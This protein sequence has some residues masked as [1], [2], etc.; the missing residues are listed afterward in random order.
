M[1]GGSVGLHT[2]KKSC[3]PAAQELA[4]VLQRVDDQMCLGKKK[5]SVRLLGMIGVLAGRESGKRGF[6]MTWFCSFSLQVHN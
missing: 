1:R 3:M 2:E 6:R 5:G 4:S